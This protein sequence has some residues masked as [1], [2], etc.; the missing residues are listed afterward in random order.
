MGKPGPQCSI[1][2]HDRRAAIEV[3]L[4]GGMGHRS[5]AARFGVSRDAVQR[6][7]RNHMPPQARAAILAA[8][9]P[10]GEAVDVDALKRDEAEGL[11]SNILASRARLA[12]LAEQAAE[13]GDT[14]GAAAVE[15]V[16]L[17]NLTLGARLVGQLIHVHEHRSLVLTPDYLVLRAE[18]LRA[19]RR[20]PDALAEVTAALAKIE[21]AGAMIEGTAKHSSPAAALPPPIEPK[22]EPVAPPC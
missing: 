16:I 7:G 4:V 1:C 15:R 11:L 18:L 20:H 8:R 17:E 10:G 14:R 9:A 12:Q 22:A 3:A 2:S 19:L 13:Q 6:H 21:T 5:V